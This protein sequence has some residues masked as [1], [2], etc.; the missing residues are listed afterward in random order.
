MKNFLSTLLLL[1]A[2]FF[3]SFSVQA[4]NIACPDI[5]SPHYQ[6][7]FNVMPVSI[8][9]GYSANQLHA[10][11]SHGDPIGLYV[12]NKDISI[13]PHVKAL[14]NPSTGQICARLSDI[15]INFNYQPQI[16]IASES[17]GLSC[18][19]QRVLNHEKTH[20][21]IEMRAVES[22][23][24][25]IASLVSPNFNHP[26]YANNKSDLEHL[27]AQQNQQSMQNIRQFFEQQTLPYHHQLDTPENY[28]HEMTY[29]SDQ[30][31]N[32]LFSRLQAESH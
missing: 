18:T 22:L 31:N 28:Q 27:L 24:E 10:M 12:G 13:E 26:F 19:M 29:C 23:K 4:Q 25:H 16:H 21:A 7:N 9:Y 3:S 2:G 8:D 1:F 6:I 30:E 32:I 20:Y 5:P 14:T 15:T 17:Q 11:S